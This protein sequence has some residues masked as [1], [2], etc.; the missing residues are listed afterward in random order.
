MKILISSHFFY[1][2][3]GGLEE[4]SYILAEEFLKLGHEVK[5]VTQTRETGDRTLPYPVLRAPGSEELLAAVRWCDVFFHNNPSL[6]TAWPLLRC[7]RPWVVTH[8]T[9]T[10]RATGE[11]TARDSFKHRVYRLARNISI[12]EAVAKSL[13]VPSVVIGNPYRAAQFQANP[14]VA[15]DRDLVYL[16]RLVSQK[17]VDILLDALARLRVAD[18]RPSLTIVGKGPD[19]ALL[20]EQAAR[21][22]IAEQVTFAGPKRDQ[23]LVDLLSAHR[24]MVV[25]SRWNEPFGVVALEGAACGCV[26]LGSN[27][28]GLKDAIGTAGDTFPNGDAASLASVLQYWLLAPDVLDGFRAAAPAHLAKFH[29]TAVAK[30]YLEVF[31]EACGKPV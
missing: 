14:A 27:G 9:W 10:A 8:Q 28:G 29:P 31:A 18:L 2:S 25:P 11:V 21:L 6:G 15:R 22:G 13:C 23:E 20:K 17:G 24:I 7:R 3:I 5:V 1:P 12:S 30:R 16:G 19:E 26:V 4:V